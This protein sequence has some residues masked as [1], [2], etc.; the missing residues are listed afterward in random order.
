MKYKHLIALGLTAIT[1][2][3]FALSNPDGSAGLR[4]GAAGQL[5]NNLTGTANNSL[6]PARPAGVADPISATDGHIGQPISG[7]APPMVHSGQPRYNK[8]LIRNVLPQV[9]Q[10]AKHNDNL[11]PNAAN[12]YIYEAISE[13]INEHAI[14]NAWLTAFVA[15]GIENDMVIPARITR[16]ADHYTI[17]LF[18]DGTLNFDVSHL[19]EAMQSQDGVIYL[20]PEV[21][22]NIIEHSVSWGDNLE[23]TNA[24]FDGDTVHLS[25]N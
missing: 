7:N 19:E 22:D 21:I 13:N 6:D 12:H 20:T 8:E 17:D 2:T 11:R 3:A 18:G 1:S 14:D 4:D 5:S 23:V 15:P 10:A 24:S 25:A 16:I 9:L